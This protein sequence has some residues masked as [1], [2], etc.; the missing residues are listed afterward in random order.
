MTE[1]TDLPNWDDDRLRQELGDLPPA[2]MPDEVWAQLQQAFVQEHQA[3]T[4]PSRSRRPWL[5]VAGAAAA[6]VIVGGVLFGASRSPSP[7]PVA[8]TAP[9]ALSSSDRS[10]IANADPSAARI[11]TA[12][13]AP[14]RMVL[15]SDTNYEKT[16]I[17]DQIGAL[18]AGVGVD[19]DT[20][21]ATMPQAASPQT[22]GSTGFTATVE[23]LRDCLTSLTQ[24]TT[25]QALVVDRAQFE[26]FDAGVLILP[27]GVA[28]EG[29]PDP[30]MTAQTSV[31]PLDVW[32]VDPACDVL[33]PHVMLHTSHDLD[34]AASPSAP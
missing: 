28:A 9:T 14:A 15:A 34:D 26:G 24:N 16:R 23:G 3:R 18:L 7:T 6:V 4:T 29:T 32:V 20:D 22:V 10:A 11:V 30:S 5:L 27:S 19:D 31:G 8:E 12:G 13:L 33:D 25:V 21:V 2:S 1:P 17:R